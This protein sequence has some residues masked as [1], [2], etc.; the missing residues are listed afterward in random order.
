M[1]FRMILLNA[2]YSPFFKTWTINFNPKWS[3]YYLGHTEKH[4]KI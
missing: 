4:I 3:I 2:F 1:D